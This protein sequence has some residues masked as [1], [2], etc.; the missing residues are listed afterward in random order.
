MKIKVL[1]SR[2]PKRAL[3]LFSV[4]VIGML[5]VTGASKSS[6]LKAILTFSK[7]NNVFYL[8][9]NPAIAKQV[10]HESQKCSLVSPPISQPRR[11]PYGNPDVQNSLNIANGI[12]GSSASLQCQTIQV[13]GPSTDQDAEAQFLERLGAP[14]STGDWGYWNSSGDYGDFGVLRSSCFVI[15]QTNTTK[16]KFSSV[17]SQIAKSGAGGYPGLKSTQAIYWGPDS[18][19]DSFVLLWAMADDPCISQLAFTVGW[20]IPANS[21]K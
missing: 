1:Q 8:E 9:A 7:S 16:A 17:V 20:T 18:L 19:T 10:T 11:D 12:D 2:P 14:P 3:I 6:K 4:V 5:L 21:I 15:V 13:K